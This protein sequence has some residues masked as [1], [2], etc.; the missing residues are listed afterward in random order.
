MPRDRNPRRGAAR[1][2]LIL[3][4]NR[5]KMNRRMRIRTVWATTTPSPIRR[6]TRTRTRT[7][8]RPRRDWRPRSDRGR[9]LPSIAP[10]STFRT[11]KRARGWR[12]TPNEGER[13]RA[14]TA[15]I[16]RRRPAS[17]P[18]ARPTTTIPILIERFEKRV[19]TTAPSRGGR[20]DEKGSA[21]REAKVPSDRYN[22]TRR[23]VFVVYVFS[24]SSPRDAREAHTRISAASPMNGSL[25]ICPERHPTAARQNATNTKS[26]TQL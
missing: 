4:T 3:K 16:S 11:R 7:G 25:Y 10:R 1:Q 26:H 24:V 20:N 5:R 17:S 14:W 12:W 18:W 9:R 22:T 13:A 8:T 21:E 23:R 19:A 15:S 6:M 2:S